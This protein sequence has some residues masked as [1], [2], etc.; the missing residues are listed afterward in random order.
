[1]FRIIS[2]VLSGQTST[3]GKESPPLS[4]KEMSFENTVMYEEDKREEQQPTSSK[5]WPGFGIIKA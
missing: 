4:F 5:D 1:M 2:D 3:T